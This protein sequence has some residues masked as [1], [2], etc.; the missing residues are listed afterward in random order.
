[1][2]FVVSLVA[3]VALGMLAAPLSAQ[4][5][6]VG[7]KA[8]IDSADPH[9]LFT[10]NRNLDLH[11]YEPLVSQDRYLK[12]RPGLAVSWTSIEPT[13]WE[14]HLRPNVTFSDGTPFTADDVVFSLN[15][16]RT[17]SGARTYRP[18]LKDIA[19]VEAVDPATVRIR[20]AQPSALLPWNLSTIGMV[21]ARAAKDATSEDFNGGRAAVGTGPYRWVKWHR[22]RDVVL[23]RNVGYWGGV[24]PWNRVVVRVIPNDSARVSALLSGDVDVID[25]V[26]GNLVGRISDAATTGLVTDTSIFLAYLHL[27]QSRDQSP[28]VRAKD[29]APLGR[30]PLKD[31]R[32]RKAL[33]LAINRRGLADRVMQGDAE[34]SGQLAPD[35]YAGHDPTL[36]P[37]A[38]DPDSA[39]ALLAA[40]GYPDG[41]RSTIHCMNDR[42]AGDA[43]VC[44]AI[45]SMFT[46]IGV[47]TEVETMPAA[48]FF[49]RG[50]VQG[51]KG[52]PDFSVSLAIYGPLTG[53]PS[54]TLTNLLQTID[55]EHGKGLIN[56][57]LY[58]NPDLDRLIETAQ[59]TFD[60]ALRNSLL[61]QAI[62]IAV[63]DEAMLPLFFLKSS[64][65][66][67]RPLSLRPRGDGY[68]MA[69]GIR[70]SDQADRSAHGHKEE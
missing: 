2:K 37:H 32:V 70:R 29:G 25:A 6:H 10:T 47:A 48:V 16:G 51:S 63:A 35:G 31:A 54:I 59:S 1:M 17:L 45:A 28:F 42:F 39:K 8:S 33:G 18:Y 20:T 67:A 43:Q 9:V 12:P 61:A 36:A 5:L 53:D 65:G 57:A 52:V 60:E 50:S 14:F 19:A 49:K 41:F 11:V 3:A 15:R 7:L 26:P 30:N 23:E 44:Q 68:T 21:S 13:V 55:R 69:T 58:S 34:P 40:A 27:D 64:W 56:R 66:I 62:R 24:E 22:G 46:A 38:Y 4:E